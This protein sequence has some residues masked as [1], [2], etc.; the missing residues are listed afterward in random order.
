MKLRIRP[1]Q[2]KLLCGVISRKLRVNSSTGLARYLLRHNNVYSASGSINEAPPHAQN[3]KS[4]SFQTENYN[5][6]GDHCQPHERKH[7]AQASRTLGERGDFLSD[8]TL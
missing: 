3:Q 1:P 5:D 6:R 7:V 2:A 4:V 8:L